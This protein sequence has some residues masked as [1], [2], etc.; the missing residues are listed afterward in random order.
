MYRFILAVLLSAA[1]FITAC[2][3]DEDNGTGPDQLTEVN[4]SFSGLEPLQNG[5]HYEGW[6]ILDGQPV[7][8][9]KFNVDAGGNF[10][11]L[12]SNSIN[13]TFAT[14]QNDPLSGATAVVITIEPAGDTD[15]VPAAT[16]ILGG[17]LSNENASLTTAHGAT[18]GSD[19]SSAAGNFILATPTT[20]ATDDEN[21]GI[22][23]LD[24]S[25]GSPAVGLTLPTLPAGWAYEGWAVVNGT[26]VTT[27]RFTAV[28]A[29]DQSAPFSGQDAS[30]P[31]FPGED[32]INNAPSGLT[33]PTDLA[34]GT[35]VISIEPEPD[36]SAAPFTLKPL[37]QMISASATDHT[38]YSMGNNA[39]AF[40]TGT[41]SLQ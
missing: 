9:G 37:V 33:F 12:D 39:A 8:T 30:G 35:A 7:S 6:V 40:P 4:L 31:P 11:D 24:L 15:A 21:S 32:L 41:A 13:G 19:F 20:S 16:K 28:D 10:T 34:G 36:D 18:L 5:Y 14:A 29:A 27:G 17:D 22:W 25:S 26:P 23:F 1:L 38:T 3:P 2:S